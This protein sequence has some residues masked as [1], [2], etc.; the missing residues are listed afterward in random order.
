MDETTFGPSVRLSRA[1]FATILYRLEGE[2]AVEYDPSAFKDVVNG[3]FYTNAAMWA[4]E[5][6]V[7]SGYADGGFGPADDITREQMAVMMFRYAQY[8]EF[9]VA[10]RDNLSKFP[11]K[12]MVSDFAKDGIS[13]AVGIGLITGDQGKISPQGSA[14]RAQTATIIQRFMTK[15]GE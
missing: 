12:N 1:Q 5:T 6:G 11:D 14:E 2:P 15:Y 4:K 7:I 9:D 8:R 13:W 3:Q 10:A